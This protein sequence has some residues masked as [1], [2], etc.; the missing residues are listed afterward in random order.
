MGDAAGKSVQFILKNG[1]DPENT[2][3]A[4]VIDTVKKMRDSNVR[5]LRAQEKNLLKPL[6]AQLNTL[7]GS[8]GELI[9]LIQARIPENQPAEPSREPDKAIKADD[10]APN[11]L[12]FAL[13]KKNE[14]IKT[15][16]AI[17]NE[18]KSSFK[19][20]NGR[21]LLDIDKSRVEELVEQFFES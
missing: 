1:Y 14:Q 11:P 6:S 2:D 21:I 8:M 4:T 20:R 10:K 18:L 13:D 19:E 3:D 17:I 5:F 16:F 7:N 9:T 12:K 15:H